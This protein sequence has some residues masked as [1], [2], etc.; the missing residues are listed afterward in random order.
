MFELNYN[1]YHIIES[2]VIFAVTTWYS[3]F[4]NNLQL[5]N[6][7]FPSIVWAYRCDINSPFSIIN[8]THEL[9]NCHV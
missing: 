2:Q 9:K 5:I 6:S 4:S 1:Y 8:H 7:K 3:L